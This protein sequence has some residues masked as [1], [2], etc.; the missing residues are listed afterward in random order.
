MSILYHTEE[1]EIHS[2]GPPQYKFQPVLTNATRFEN[3][4]VDQV[5]G[6][7]VTKWTNALAVCIARQPEKQFTSSKLGAGGFFNSDIDVLNSI[8][9]SKSSSLF[10]FYLYH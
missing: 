2:T 6:R 3:V 8:H 10:G 1:V 4:K 7:G 5:L 9:P